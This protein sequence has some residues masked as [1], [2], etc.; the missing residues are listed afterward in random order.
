MK[1]SKT[2]ECQM[3]LERQNKGIN[4]VSNTIGD[5]DKDN[6]VDNDRIIIITN[7]IIIITT[8]LRWI[9]NHAITKQGNMQ[10]RQLT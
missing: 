1:N 6:Y 2:Y 7:R 9:L 3:L 10:R 5:S 4:K 8:R